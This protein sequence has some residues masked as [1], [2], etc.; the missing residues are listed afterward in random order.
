MIE[1]LLTCIHSLEK[2]NNDLD[3]FILYPNKLEGK[4]ELYAIDLQKI[5]NRNSEAIKKEIDNNINKFNKF[6]RNEQS[7]IYVFFAEY[8]YSEN[9]DQAIWFNLLKDIETDLDK[10]KIVKVIDAIN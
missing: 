9:F 3:S 10:E 8:L 4:F 6:K 5:L 2:F 1:S 7:L